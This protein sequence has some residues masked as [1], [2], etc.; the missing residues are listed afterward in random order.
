MQTLRA[1]GR[2]L[3]AVVHAL[4]GIV[5]V[6]LRF[7]SLGLIARRQK[8]AWWSARMLKILGL[9]LNLQ[10]R[11]HEGAKLIVANHVSWLDIMAIHAVCPHARFVAKAE[12]RHWPVIRHLVDCAGTIYIER[13]RKRD[14]LRVVHQVA[15]ALAAGDTVAIFPEGTTGP[16]SQLLPFHANLLQAAI[17]G[18][19][20][21]QPVLLRFAD[22]QNAFSPSAAYVGDITLFGSLWMLARGRGLVVHVT[23]MPAQ[24]CEQSDRRL[25]AQ[26]LRAQMAAVLA[27]T[28]A[29]S[30]AGSVAGSGG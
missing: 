27:A 15:Q 7:P 4:H 23:V 16:G 24:G 14:A 28:V 21:V 18:G 26:A 5:I 19:A 1:V 12:V 25:L 3:F 22:A 6:L 29:S 2:L 13:E 8:I 30:V 10:G 9:R 11:W 20:T 17:S